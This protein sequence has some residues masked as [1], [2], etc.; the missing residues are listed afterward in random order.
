MEP[1]LS[2]SQYSLF[3]VL[4]VS[5]RSIEAHISAFN[6]SSVVSQNERMTKAEQTELKF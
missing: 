3:S 6:I 1:V 5:P 2:H 4:K